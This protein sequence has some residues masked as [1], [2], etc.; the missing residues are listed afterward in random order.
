MQVMQEEDRA[1]ESLLAC[2][3]VM[4]EVGV[5]SLLIDRGSGVQLVSWGATLR[6]I[7][8]SCLWLEAPPVACWRMSWWE[9]CAP[10]WLGG[11]GICCLTRAWGW[12]A[13][14]VARLVMHG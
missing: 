12:T 2:D 7:G 9:W 1:G 13:E 5:A 14:T 6:A 4:A 3:W 8:W 10:C 11:P